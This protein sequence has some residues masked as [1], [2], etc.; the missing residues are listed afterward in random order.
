MLERP[1]NVDPSVEKVRVILAVKN[2]AAIQGV[3]HIG[4][5]VTATNTMKVLRKNGVHTEAW[6]TQTYLELREKLSKDAH[7]ER[8]RDITHVIVSAPS[9]IQPHQFK[10]LCFIYP[11]IE[12]V[13]L[14]HSGCAFLSIDRLGIQNI[15]ECIDLELSMHNMRVASNNPRVTGT[16]T[17]AFG[18]EPDCLL[19]PNLYDT[20]TFVKPYPRR[21]YGNTLHIGNF[22]ASRP[23]K[24]QLTAALAAIQLS[25][26][27]GVRLEY[28]VNSKRPDGGEKMITSREEMFKNLA[29]CNINY[30]PWE[31]WPK[32]RDTISTMNI[33]FQPSFDETF[34]VVTADGLAEGVASVTAPCIEWTPSSWW[35][36]ECDP[37]S[38]VDVAIRLLHDPH[39]VEFGRRELEKYVRNG[40]RLWL[41]YLLKK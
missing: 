10:E 11:D 39:A 4:L 3:C 6:A 19:L 30:V 1:H 17:E 25:R 35:C 26:R 15:R 37:S 32:F 23:W 31:M 38:M 13:Q 16:L 24:N 22:G 21:E 27:L 29:G 7:N 33:L 8:T 2:F 5:G 40:L 9:W 14:N 28:Y 20:D 12:F 18:M 36:E 41:D 34:N